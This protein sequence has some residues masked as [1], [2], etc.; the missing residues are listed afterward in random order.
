MV[1]RQIRQHRPRHLTS[2]RHAA[3]AATLLLSLSAPAL[4][5]ADHLEAPGVMGRGDVDLADLYAFQSPNNPDNS[6]LVLT[7]NPFAGQVSGTDFS[8]AASYNFLIDNDGDAIADITYSTTFAAPVGGSQVVTTT[9]TITGNAPTTYA[10][11]QT[12]QNLATADGGM[13]QAD[14]FE[15]PFFFDLAGFSNGFNFTGTDAFAGAN[16]SAIV[17]ELPSLELGGPNIGVWATTVDGNGQVDR[18]GRPAI[19]TALIP[20]GQKDAFNQG[21]PVDDPADFAAAVNATLVSLLGGDQATANSLTGV[22]LPDILTFD[23]S[24]SAGFLNGR[25]LTDDV[26]D[27]VL[28]LVSNG[29]ITTDMVDANDTAFA[30]LFPYLAAPNPIQVAGVPVPSALALTLFGA[31]GMVGIRRR[32]KSSGI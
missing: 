10:M 30:S 24:S 25:N 18:V 27:A 20:A 17:L 14:L 28:G 5:A 31:I 15:D 32:R 16:V 26:I 13:L 12:G 3:V 22:L 23:T 6:V 11:G 8:T 1:P 4:Y 19:N 7:V 9:R 29:A 2:P 21:Q